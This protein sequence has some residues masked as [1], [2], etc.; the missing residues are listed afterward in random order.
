MRKIDETTLP[1]PEEKLRIL[2]FSIQFLQDNGY[3]MIGMD[4]FAKPD[5][6]LFTSIQKGQLRR[7]FQG[8]STKGGTQTIGIGLTSI[9]EGVDYYAQNFKTMQEV[10]KC[11]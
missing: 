3:K 1:S 9:G 5:D 2:E 8:Y 6:T 7:N 4:H 11:Y 10:S